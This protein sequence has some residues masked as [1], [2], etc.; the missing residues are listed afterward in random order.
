MS[1]LEGPGDLA[2]VPLAAVL[3]DAL[4]QRATGVLTV[5]HGNGASRVFL[6]DGIP[7]GAQSFCDFRPL[8][9]ALLAAGLIDVE[10]LGQS[11]AEMARSGRPQ[12]ELLIE[13]GAVTR[14]Q[15]DCALTEQ[16]AAYL[17]DI[18]GLAAGRF[19]FDPGAPIPPWTQE[20][21]I[22]PLR[23]IVDALEKPQAVPLVISALQPAAAAPLS[24]APGYRQLAPAF[25]FSQVEAALVD[26]L[27]SLTTLEVFFSEPGVP[28]ERA[29]AIMA[30]LLLLGLALS[31][32]SQG[33]VMESVPGLVVD[34]A[35]LAGVPIEAEP[36]PVRA[37]SGAPASAPSME[38]ETGDKAYPG[39]T[40][41]PT[42]PRIA[43]PPARRSDPQEARRRRQRLLQRAMQNMGVGPLS[44]QRPPS[45]R[46]SMPTSKEA[47]PAT[48][49][50]KAEQEL[51]LSLEAAIPRAREKDL[52]KRLGLPYKATREEVKAAYLHLAR[53]LH[54]DRFASA[55]LADLADQVRDTF[56]AFNEAYEVLA[57]DR[58]RA[59]YLARSQASTAVDGQARKEEAM[60][61]FQK[62][63]AC[64]RT[65]DF[66]KA[67]AFYEAA[68]RVDARPEYQV[69]YAWALL[70]DPNGDK[71]RAKI[72]AEA[73][74]LDRAC[75]ERAALVCAALARHEGDDEKGER[76]LRQVLQ[77]N[78]RNAEAERELRALESRRD[79]ARQTLA[80]SS[81]RKAKR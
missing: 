30:A 5:E 12:G 14:E 59:E 39:P 33:E 77:V 17:A 56:A 26:R 19:A 27:H 37:L 75:A 32:S 21:R 46:V 13:M 2:Q 67:R 53:Q 24:L 44:G 52:F 76:L 60:V 38:G 57:D 74:L 16:Q 7:V 78:P 6:R 66:L 40:S 4:N 72:L 61:D 25:G 35:D 49:A 71:A 22:S 42:A 3:I 9:Q 81:S 41:P 36:S 10:E 1:L 18:A 47:R 65:R 58:K 50:S 51:R 55:Q 62:A 43:T 79:R 45:A 29:R 23:A 11:L 73:A 68:L 48:P 63:E 28:P 31:R 8:G 69:A 80:G 70:Q 54:P 20:I 15:V 64:T 34:L